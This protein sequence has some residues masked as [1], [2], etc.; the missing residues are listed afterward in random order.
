MTALSA[1][2]LTLDKNRRFYE[3]FADNVT[4][5]HYEHDLTIVNWSEGGFAVALDSHTAGWHVGKHLDIKG[6]IHFLDNVYAFSTSSVVRFIDHERCVVG[7]QFYMLSPH[8]A[9]ILR[10]LAYAKHHKQPLIS[11]I[12]IPPAPEPPPSLPPL[13]PSQ[14]RWQRIGQVGI[15]IL[16]MISIAT[17]YATIDRHFYRVNA[18]YALL[19]A[20][21]YVLQAPADGSITRLLPTQTT[22]VQ[23]GQPIARIIPQRLLEKRSQLS[24]K[25]SKQQQIIAALEEKLQRDANFFS[26]YTAIAKAEERKAI[27][28]EAF[29]QRHIN[30]LTAL[31]KNGHITDAVLD[32]SQHTLHKA[33]AQRLV[34]EQNL[35]LAQEGYFYSGSRIDGGAE[36]R[37]QK[38]F[39]LAQAELAALEAEAI[40]LDATLQNME[41]K[42]PC[43]CL[44]YN[45][46][47]Q[48][49]SFVREGQPLLTL[50]EDMRR[51]PN[52]K[53]LSR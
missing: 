16:V 25:L 26:H 22:H 27:E 11:S 33:M 5:S 4:F 17:A 19:V 30:R 12:L 3:R 28:E 29:Q 23:Q 43:D 6:F 44:I 2:I 21:T 36:R 38:E 51:I 52:S 15:I 46:T 7:L 53:L 31:H 32:A 24:I 10:G 48:Q 35:R 13:T 40:A 41:L 47:L 34:A 8:H 49:T 1:A 14:L 37:L 20:P 45:E 9:T 18:S 42:S 50:Y 39:T